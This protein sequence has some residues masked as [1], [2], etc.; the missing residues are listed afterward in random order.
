MAEVST[1][2]DDNW[3][4][5]RA[6]LDWATPV[7]TTAVDPTILD[8]VARGIGRLDAAAHRAFTVEPINGGPAVFAYAGNF[9]EELA[10][11]ADQRRFELTQF[12]RCRP[13]HP[14]RPL[15]PLD[16][17][18]V[19]LSTRA[20]TVVWSMGPDDV[21]IDVDTSEPWLLGCGAAPSYGPFGANLADV[22]TRL[23]RHKLPVDALTEA[24][25]HYNEG[26][27]SVLGDRAPHLGVSR[28]AVLMEVAATGPVGSEA[29]EP[30]QWALVRP[31]QFDVLVPLGLRQMSNAE[32]QS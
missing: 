13:G 26:L 27:R 15:I 3:M 20:A 32:E 10:V 29:P 8:L 4:G 5:N 23:G 18:D 21:R 14:F 19:A 9:R 28:F 30:E 11:F 17:I 12:A 24:V 16:D 22:F 31:E 25:G 2:Y 6:A 7:P 1:D